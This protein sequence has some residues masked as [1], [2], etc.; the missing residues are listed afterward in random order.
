MIN[1]MLRTT[2]QPTTPKKFIFFLYISIREQKK[3]YINLRKYYE[4]I[5]HLHIH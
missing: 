2:N 4:R 3:T 5:A 1:L